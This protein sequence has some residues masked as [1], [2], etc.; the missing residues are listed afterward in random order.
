MQQR[1]QTSGRGQAI[2]KTL[3]KL[4]EPRR[5]RDRDHVKF[6][7]KQPCQYALGNRRMPTICGSFKVEHLGAKSAMSSPFQCVEDTTAKCIAVE[8]KLDGEGTLEL[9]QP[10]P[11]AGYGLRPIP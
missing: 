4:P 6:V 2:D 5:V 3:L 9:I 7:S 8:M 1:S 11:L 10:L